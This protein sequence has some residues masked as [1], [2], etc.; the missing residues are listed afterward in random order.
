MCLCRFA[1]GSVPFL[2]IRGGQTEREM[3]LCNLKLHV[4]CFG[5]CAGLA[6][7]SEVLSSIGGKT[8]FL[9]FCL[10]YFCSQSFLIPRSF[11]AVLIVSEN[12]KGS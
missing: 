11:C 2:V 1:S 10:C 4:A 7:L 8:L 9:N 12:K 5:V 3:L 6:A